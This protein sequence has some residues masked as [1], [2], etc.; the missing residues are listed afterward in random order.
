MAENVNSIV[1]LG[2]TNDFGWTY[3]EGID[4]YFDISYSS[5]LAFSVVS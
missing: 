1:I 2:N 5:L 4:V 3:I